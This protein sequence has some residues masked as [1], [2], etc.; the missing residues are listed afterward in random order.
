MSGL[1]AVTSVLGHVRGINRALV[2]RPT[3]YCSSVSFIMVLN[4]LGGFLSVRS[5]KLY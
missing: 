3:I 5:N 4:I 1:F 2:G